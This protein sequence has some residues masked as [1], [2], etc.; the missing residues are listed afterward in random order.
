MKRIVNTILLVTIVFA[1]FA[2]TTPIK[3]QIDI[4]ESTI[5]WKG[6]KV[7][8]KSHIGTIDLKEGYFEFENEALVGGHFVIDMTSISN[9]D[10]EGEYKAKLEGHL[11]SDDFFGVEKYPT[12]SFKINKASKQNDRYEITGDLTIKGITNSISFDLFMNG[13][14]STAHIE[15]DRS[16]FDVRYGSGSFFDDLGDKTISD[17]IELEV[18]LKH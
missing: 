8:G 7:I 5:T 18:T 11:K 4:K 2:F 14:T 15:F 12:A 3:K 10:V 16:K 1:A 6:E 13:N 17:T 9:T